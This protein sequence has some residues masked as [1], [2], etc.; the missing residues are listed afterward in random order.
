MGLFWLSLK[1][2]TLRKI[3]G[4]IRVVVLLS[5]VLMVL[6]LFWFDIYKIPSISM[7]RTLFVGDKIIIRKNTTPEHND[8]IVFQ[9]MNIDTLTLVKR[10]V[11]LPGDTLS[12]YQNKV[13]CNAQAIKESGTLQ[14]TYSIANAT[15][16]EVEDILGRTVSGGNTGTLLSASEEDKL[17]K[18]LPHIELKKN[19][20]VFGIRSKVFPNNK[21][22][23]N[24]RDNFSSFIVP[25]KGL[26][27]ELDSINILWYR[28]YIKRENMTA[29]TSKNGQIYMNGDTTCH[30]TFKEDYYYVMGDNRHRS[31]DSRF[32]GFIAASNIKGKVIQIWSQKR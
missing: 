30:Y 10:C 24:N 5:F 18:E 3:L 20:M 6:R 23:S 19:S 32:F 1:N 16:Q 22:L 12:M 9:S 29:R 14:W 25:A 15:H 4:L 2:K 28:K 26:S 21:K 17:R 31:I 27:V 11:G 7:E 13:F 8:I